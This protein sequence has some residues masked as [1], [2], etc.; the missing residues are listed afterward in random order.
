MDTADFA[1]EGNGTR[2]RS[3]QLAL[4]T[5]GL[6]EWLLASRNGL[7]LPHGKSRRGSRM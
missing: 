2:M 1:N 7:R 3:L 6:D 4:W 5:L